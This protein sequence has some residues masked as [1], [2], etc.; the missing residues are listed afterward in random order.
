MQQQAN[1]ILIVKDGTGTT[2]PVCEAVVADKAIVGIVEL[3]V[4]KHNIWWIK[5]LLDNMYILIPSL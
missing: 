5:E 1:G 3:Q 4:L 2:D